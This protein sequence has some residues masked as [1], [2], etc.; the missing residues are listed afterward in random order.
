MT[1]EDN[2][3]HWPSDLQQVFVAI[4]R[5]MAG[6]RLRPEIAERALPALKR[7]LM[8]KRVDVRHGAKGSSDERH[9]TIDIG[10]PT[11]GGSWRFR[12]GDLEKLCLAAA[13]APA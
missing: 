10:G 8:P 2:P 12:S 4:G 13:K 6:G 1:S 7:S 3:A 9:Y 11:F 5:E